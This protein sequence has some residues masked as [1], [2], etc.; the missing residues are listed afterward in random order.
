[1]L[2]AEA[3]AALAFARLRAGETGFKG[4]AQSEGVAPGVAV[5][6]RSQYAR[7]IESWEAMG[8]QWRTN[9]AE[10]AQDFRSGRAEVD[11]KRYPDTCRCCSLPALCRINDRTPDESGA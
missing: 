8:A 2:D 11:P 3:V 6:D 1:L 7:E 5:F 4:L 10:L 9:L